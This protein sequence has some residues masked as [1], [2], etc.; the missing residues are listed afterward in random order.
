MKTTKWIAIWSLAV[1]GLAAIGLAQ[2]TAAVSYKIEQTR[3]GTLGY[4]DAGLCIQQ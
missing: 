3:L 1:T 2:T 4:G